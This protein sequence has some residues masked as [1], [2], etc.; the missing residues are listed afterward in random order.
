M[1]E[2]TIRHP[3]DVPILERLSYVFPLLPEMVERNYRAADAQ[4]YL[5]DHPEVLH[6]L[7]EAWHTALINHLAIE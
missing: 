4:G 6:D 7:I 2:L 1:E 3:S 5:D